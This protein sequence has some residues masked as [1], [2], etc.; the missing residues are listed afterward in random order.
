MVKQ[1]I[2]YY[3]SCLVMLGMVWTGT[4]TA[5]QTIAYR[6]SNLASSL[7]NVSMHVTPGLV[8]PWGVAFL[9]DQSFFI[10]GNKAG[11]VI[12]LDATGLGVSPSGFTVPNSS[13]TG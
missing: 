7:P 3:F 11:R 4:K 1:K 12:S 2:V 10:A 8:N 6:Q 5:A 13:G 9:R